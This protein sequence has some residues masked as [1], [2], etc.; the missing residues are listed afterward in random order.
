MGRS[1]QKQVFTLGALEVRALCPPLA[2]SV[3]FTKA[4]LAP[5]LEAS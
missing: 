5:Q 2:Q 1:L 3:L 4:P